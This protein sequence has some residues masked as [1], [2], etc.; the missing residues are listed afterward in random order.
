[1]I[2]STTSPPTDLTELLAVF[3]EQLRERA[4]PPGRW[5]IERSGRTVREW[6][7]GYATV[8]WSDLNE[9]AA[10]AAVAAAQ[11]WAEADRL[12]LE[13][14]LYGHDTPPDLPAR[15]A[16]A[17][18]VAEPQETLMVAEIGGLPQLPEPPAGVRL[19]ELAPGDGPV[20][21][22][23]LGAG[24][25][26]VDALHRAVWGER[27]S[28]FR[29]QLEEE[30]ALRPDLLSIVIAEPAGPVE[31]VPVLCAGW[32][33]IHQGTRFGSL[34]GGSTLPQWRGRGIYRSTVAW[35][36]ARAAELGMRWLTVDASD[37]SRPILE[38]LGFRRLS[39]TTPY[40]WDG[41]RAD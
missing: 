1:V 41:S 10:D 5:S 26:A 31:P 39:T 3:D 4:L 6:G 11:H 34:W 23:A 21:R 32:L 2:D 35:R 22:E 18:F 24:L 25:G 17:G 20:D 9:S 37:D 16:A 19:R 14:K 28:G 38:R 29:E 13:W 30:K 36:A 40:I 33:R 27:P 7:D 8:V 12:R 15:L